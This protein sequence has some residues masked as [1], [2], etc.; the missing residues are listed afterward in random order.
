VARRLTAPDRMRRLLAIVP[1]VVANPGQRVADVA[2]RFGVSEKQLIA[3]L[4]VALYVGLPPYSP[5]VLMDVNFD[6]DRVSI[7][8]ADFFARPLR[9][10]AYQGLA[11]WAA[12]DALLSVP[13][14]DPDGALARALAKLKPVV[15]PNADGAVGVHLGQADHAIIDRLRS[16]VETEKLVEIDYYS[17]G[18]DETTTRTVVPWHVFSEAGAWYLSGWCTRAESK[19]V[20]RLDRIEKL[21]VTDKAAGSVD[22]PERGSSGVFEPRPDDPRVRLKLSPE[23][24]WVADVYPVAESVHHDDGFVEVELVVTAVPWL[25]RLLLRLGPLAEIVGSD[26]LADPDDLVANAA[27]RVLNCYHQ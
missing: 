25:E 2:A 12:S 9:L 13:G 17:Y 8:L 23:A 20:F 16:A 22:V 4:S 7:L 26:G 21:V 3:D 24:S 11:L 1:W 10:S 6:N 15:A 14:T 5:D 18:R 27:R 19:R